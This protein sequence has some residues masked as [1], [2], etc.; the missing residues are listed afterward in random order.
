MGD[1]TAQ[2]SSRAGLFGVARR[3]ESPAAATSAGTNG[4]L[5]LAPQQSRGAAPQRPLSRGAAQAVSVRVSAGTEGARW[6]CCASL[7]GLARESDDGET[8]EHRARGGSERT[9]ERDVPVGVRASDTRPRGCP[10]GRPAA[11]TPDAKDESSF[12][13]LLP[14]LP[15]WGDVELCGFGIKQEISEPGR[16]PMGLQ[17]WPPKGASRSRWEKRPTTAL[18]VPS[19][20]VP[21]PCGVGPYSP[22]AGSVTGCAQGEVVHWEGHSLEGSVWA[23]ESE[24]R[25]EAWPGLGSHFPAN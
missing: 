20:A 23:A 18:P 6:R 24:P 19:V 7:L 2:D 9:A 17:S 11:R 8:S 5:A 10:R 16:T 13:A 22:Q 3:P 21:S 15:P 12:S 1:Y 14:R 4:V 25:C